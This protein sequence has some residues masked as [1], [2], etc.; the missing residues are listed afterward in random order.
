MDFGF[1]NPQA[2]TSLQTITIKDGE[3]L[4]ILPKG[5]PLAG[6][7][8]ITLAELA[9]EPYI[10]L[11]EGKYSEPMAAFEKEGLKPDIEYTIHD[12]HTII[13]MVEAG[14]G[15]SILPE[16]M[17]RRTNY[18]ISCL[19]IEPPVRRTLAVAYK[20]KDSLPIASK[21]FIDHMMEHKEELPQNILTWRI[22]I[23]MFDVYTSSQPGKKVGKSWLF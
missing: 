3:M 2:D 11:E 14:L 17:L 21:Y 9:K 8:S 10:L 18:H 20:D 16:L 15:V 19:P 4:A 13:T 1:I 22:K 5:H 6:Q 7:K 23:T 12:D